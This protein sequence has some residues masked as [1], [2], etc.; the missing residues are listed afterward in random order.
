MRTLIRA[1]LC[2]SATLVLVCLS[3]LR[4]PSLASTAQKLDLGGL[5]ERADLVV[6]GRVQ[7][8]RV[9]LD[10]RARPETEYELTLF[11]S[12]WGPASQSLVFRMP[13]GTLP[14]GS[15]MLVPG[16]PRLAPGEELLLFLTAESK[17]GQRLTVGLAQ[18]K[19]EVLRDEHGAARL[20]REA[21]DLTLVDPAG[22]Q[23]AAGGEPSAL[24][25]A[26]TSARL[27]ELAQKKKLAQTA[28]SRA[29]GAS[30]GK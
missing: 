13:G 9:Q 17:T 29:Q 23:L 11:S 10:V 22:K 5:F 7:S 2:A 27:L 24:D 20:S 19:F 12:F 16:L 14:D 1:A 21:C 18:G 3:D 28:K 15:G 26:A 25:F 8:A 6:H 4:R 30:Q